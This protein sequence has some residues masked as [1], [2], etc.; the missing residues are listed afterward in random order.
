MELHLVARSLA[1]G[2][3]SERTLNQTMFDSD[4][5]LELIQRVR[6]QIVDAVMEDRCPVVISMG[7][8]ALSHNSERLCLFMEEFTAECGAL[9][10]WLRMPKLE[11]EGIRSDTSA[12]MCPTS[13]RKGYIGFYTSADFSDPN[14]R[15][16]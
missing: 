12:I 4:N 3:R 1:A 8:N 13:V 5:A 10:V 14:L 16:G 7:V 2:R 9:N 11:I 6:A 15:C